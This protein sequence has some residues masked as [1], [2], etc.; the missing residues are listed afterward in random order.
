MLDHVP[1]ILLV[2]ARLAG[3]VIFAPILSSIAIPVRVSA[4]LS[5]LVGIAVY[6]ALS[7]EVFG[8]RTYEL[9]LLTLAPLLAAEAGIGLAIGWLA[10]LPLL[11]AQFAGML[12]GAQLG[13]GFA[14]IYNPAT[15][16]SADVV[17]QMLF[18]LGLAAFLALSGHVWVVLAVLRTFD[19][20]PV[21]GFRV[22]GDL[23]DLGAGL[24]LAAME[25]GLRIAAPVLAIVF[26]ESIAM[27]FM[28]RTTPQLNV[29]SLGFPLRI[30]VGIGMTAV[31]LYVIGD[32]LMASVHEM[33]DAIHQWATDGQES[34]EGAALGRR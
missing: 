21:G 18:W 9:D 16:A 14:E 7:V 29:L 15:D 32:V 13:L 1:Q 19:Y 12:T 33:L 31:G 27:G 25:V 23:M 4:G 5:F 26:L 34:M 6:P 20:V 30:I 3:L 28:S 10:M 11:A 22:D 8:G 17:A 2:C 24:L